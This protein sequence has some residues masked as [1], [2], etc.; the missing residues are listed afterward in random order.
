MFGMLT[1]G[2]LVSGSLSGTYA[3]PYAAP[4]TVTDATT[5]PATVPDVSASAGVREDAS[6]GIAT[7]KSRL[8]GAGIR[9][10]DAST[11]GSISWEE[12]RRRKGY[13]D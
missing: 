3:L 7:R 6:F 2:Q 11:G 1:D 13:V 5:A 8:S 9:V 4:T 10:F 12:N